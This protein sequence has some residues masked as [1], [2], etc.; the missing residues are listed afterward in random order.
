MGAAAAALPE[1]SLTQKG[2]L[3]TLHVPRVLTCAHGAPGPAVTRRDQLVSQVWGERAEESTPRQS[4]EA[5]WGDEEGRGSGATLGHLEHE[6]VTSGDGGNRG[7]GMTTQARNGRYLNHRDHT[8][9][10]LGFSLRRSMKNTPRKGLPDPVSLPAG[11]LRTRASTR[12][13]ATG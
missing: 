7:G 13:H 1:A 10:R 8:G 3:G 12:L 9:C 2:L 4:T 11:P 6:T 5:G